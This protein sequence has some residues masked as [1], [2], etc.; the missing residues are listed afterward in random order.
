MSR[1]L[2]MSHQKYV[3]SL[4]N[5]E[6]LHKAFDTAGRAVIGTVSIEETHDAENSESESKSAALLNFSKGL[7]SATTKSSPSSATLSTPS[8]DSSGSATSLKPTSFAATASIG[9]VGFVTSE[10]GPNSAAGTKIGA[11]PGFPRTDNSDTDFDSHGSV[12]SKSSFAAD[13][14][15]VLPVDVHSP[16]PPVNYPPQ[17]NSTN[18]PLEIT[19]TRTKIIKLI[20]KVRTEMSDFEK[21]ADVKTKQKLVKKATKH[22][23]N[24]EYLLPELG[25]YFIKFALKTEANKLKTPLPETLIVAYKRAKESIQTAE[26]SMKDTTLG[27]DLRQNAVE[28]SMEAL[29]EFGRKIVTAGAISSATESSTTNKPVFTVARKHVSKKK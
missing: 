19:E 25:L 24:V 2:L 7:Q 3:R 13:K 1:T 28:K 23:V 29:G 26:T 18:P 16:P 10:S 20:G 15:F 5:S 11:S 22:T 12:A 6:K 14:R 27:V 17:F 9:S 4:R 21:S 8:F